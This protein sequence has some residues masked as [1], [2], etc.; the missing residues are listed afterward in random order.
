M[1]FFLTGHAQESMMLFKKYQL[2]KIYFPTLD[3]NNKMFMKFLSQALKNTDFRIKKNKSL[4][5]GFL[6][7][8]FLWH[9]VLK[10]WETNKKYFPHTSLALNKAIDE[11]FRK[12]AKIFPIQKRFS[13]TM[14]EIWRLQPRFNS[15]SPKKIYRLLGHPKFRASYDFLL[16][17]CQTAEVPFS[18]GNWWTKFIESNKENQDLLITD[19]KKSKG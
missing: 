6:L 9:D 7:A 15:T 5:P 3:N 17:R 14:S 19:K 13:I 1:K 18:E 4:N 2:S 12:Q 10:L 11:T 8:T 16:L